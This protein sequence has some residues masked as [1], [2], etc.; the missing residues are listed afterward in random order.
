MARQLTAPRDHSRFLKTVGFLLT[1]ILFVKLG[2]FFTWSNNISIT[3]V[4]KVISRIAMT[5]SIWY[6]YRAII[7]RGAVASFGWKQSLSPFLYVVYLF[8]GLLSVM[9]STDPGYSGLQWFMDMEGLVFAYYFIACFIL[10]DYFFSGSAVKMYQVIGDAVMMMISIF[11]VGMYIDP[12]TFYRLTHGGEEARLGGFIM[13]PN[14]L[15][16]LCA[17]GVSCFIF[18]IYRKH[19]FVWTFI[20]IGLLMWAVVLTGSRSSTIG[21]LLIAFFHIR[22]SSNTKLKLAMYAGAVMVVPVAVQTLLIKEHGGGLDEVMSMTG[23]LPF[24]TALLNEGLPRA[25][26]FG[27]GFMRIATTDYFQGEHIFTYAAKMTHNTFIQVL[28]N[29]GFVGFFIVLFQLVFTIRGFLQ[30]PEK[31]KSLICV[32]VL[33]PI[34]INSF[35]EFGIFGETNY[36]ILFYQ[37]LIFYISLSINPLLTPGEKIYL[38]RRR[39]D[40]RPA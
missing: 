39:P 31:E 20:K 23:R 10:I 5:T 22:Q 12:E 11:L 21:C 25:P 36:G 26:F 2:G 28:M 4:I 6:L 15:G 17:V 35:T 3:R 16:M 9:W 19:Q 24:W 8:L 34:M 13:N 1:I 40:L 32:G 37:L 7:N 27:F 30:V 18:N 29:L 14:E 33:I 38:Y